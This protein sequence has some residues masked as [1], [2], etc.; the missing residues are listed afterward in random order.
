MN[1]NTNDY[2][3]GVCAGG[4]AF[5]LFTGTLVWNINTDAWRADAVAHDKA[6]YYLDKNHERQWRW[7]SSSLEQP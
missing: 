6:E 3:L 1:D 7:K 2:W 5:T 4:V